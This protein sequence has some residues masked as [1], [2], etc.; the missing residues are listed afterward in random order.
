MVP[1][2]RVVESFV[3]VV[4]A[5]LTLVAGW[6]LVSVAVNWTWPLVSMVA[7]AGEMEKVLLEGF[8]LGPPPQPA[9]MSTRGAAQAKSARRSRVIVTTIQGCSY[10]TCPACLPDSWT[11]LGAYHESRIAENGVPGETP[12]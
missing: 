3:P 5:Q 11:L 10:C 2:P 9:M 6:P 12:E 7:V 8:E 4:M 1:W